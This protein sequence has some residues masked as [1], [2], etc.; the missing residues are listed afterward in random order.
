M[1]FTPGIVLDA[2]QYYNNHINGICDS[3][4]T[5]VLRDLQ[6][7]SDDE[8]MPGVLAKLPEAVEILDLTN[9][10]L[11]VMPNLRDRARIHTLLLSRNRILRVEARFLPCHLRRLTLASNGIANLEDLLGL[12][13]S[14]ATLENLNLR[15][16]NVCYMENYRLYVLSMLPQ[17][18]VLDFTN[19]S[20]EERHQAQKFAS[21][22]ANV[23]PKSV[24]V[25]PQPRNTD[26]ATEVMSLVV[27]KMDADVRENLKR[28]LESAKT[29]EEMQKIEKLLSGGV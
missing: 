7:E 4:L 11:S 23:T 15:G 29:L 18:K 1:K 21:Q 22:R 9:N 5:V 20:N 14:P 25:K 13:S 3:E 17:L 6:L 26:K 8:A 27:G 10:E 2:P 24:A 28:Q 16:N 19:V 12:K